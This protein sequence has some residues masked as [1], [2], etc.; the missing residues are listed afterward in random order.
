MGINFQSEDLKYKFEKLSGVLKGLEKVIVSC[1]G[2]LDSLLMAIVA[3]TV[4]GPGN[5][6]AVT[7]DSPTLPGIDRNSAAEITG[8]YGIRHISLNLDHI[9]EIDGFKKNPVNRC[10]LCKKATYEKIWS[11]AKNEGFLSIIDGTNTDDMNDF[12]PGIKA[13]RELNVVSPFL[14]A[15]ISKNDIRSMAREMKL[16]FS[17][18]PSS[19]CL[20]SRFPYNEEIT[21]E[22]LR[23]IDTCEDFIRSKGISTVRVRSHGDI[24]RIEVGESYFNQIMNDNVRKE[25]CENIISSG[26][27]FVC[28]DM[29]GYRT[30]SMNN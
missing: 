2:G 14:E 20:S 3:S 24:A 5:V 21:R 27:K 11:F 23:R 9:D 7:V 4:L 10:Y 6:T 18:K 16:E 17:E 13:A 19:A 29:A 15:G 12:R 1:S 30:G 25:V 26:F 28:L 8:K 22:K